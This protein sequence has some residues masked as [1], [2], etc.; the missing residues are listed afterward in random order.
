[1]TQSIEE[2]AMRFAILISLSKSEFCGHEKELGLINEELW[3]RF[4]G[5]QTA[6]AILEAKATLRLVIS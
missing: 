4:G 2:L 6:D 1:M 5:Q 3:D